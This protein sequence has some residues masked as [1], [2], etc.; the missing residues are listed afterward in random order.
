MKEFEPFVIRRPT[1]VNEPEN[2]ETLFDTEFEGV[3]LSRKGRR[4]FIWK[5]LDKL[6]ENKT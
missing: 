4:Y 2:L 5:C 6:E 1:Q 3:E